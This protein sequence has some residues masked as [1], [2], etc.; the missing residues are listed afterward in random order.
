MLVKRQARCDD[1][2]LCAQRVQTGTTYVKVKG[3]LVPTPVY[4]YYQHWLTRKSSDGGASWTPSDDFQLTP[5]GSN[6]AY[7]VVDLAGTLCVAGESADHSI[8]RTS[9]GGV[10]WQTADNYTDGDSFNAYYAV[11]IDPTTGAAY[12]GATD[13][14]II[15]SGSSNVLGGSFSSMEVVSNDGTHDLLLELT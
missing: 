4:A 12:A 6:Q 1:F 3:Q 14:W 8:V 10:N 7:A 9:T 15:R 2:K 11:T 13:S 5:D